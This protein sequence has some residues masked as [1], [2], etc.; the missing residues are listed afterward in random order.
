M[1]RLPPAPSVL[2]LVGVLVALALGAGGLRLCVAPIDVSGGTTLGSTVAGAKANDALVYQAHA[3][4][5]RLLGSLGCTSEAVGLQ[6]LK[7]AA[8]ARTDEQ[9]VQA[10][11]GL[12]AARARAAQ[13]TAF[14]AQLCRYVARGFA[15]AFQARAVATAGLRCAP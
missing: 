15:N 4:L 3:S 2:W 12:A 6:W 1:R 5:G 11:V 10:A 7:A 9:V 8:H 13:P 14:D